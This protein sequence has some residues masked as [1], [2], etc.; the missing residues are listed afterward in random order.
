MEKR[1]I[2]KANENTLAFKQ[3]VLEQLKDYIPHDLYH[4]IESYEPTLLERNDFIKRNRHKNTVPIEER[5][6]AKSA[7]NDQ[8]TRRRKNGHTCCGT[9]SK[10]VPHGLMSL[11]KTEQ[12]ELIVQDIE[13]ILYY[14]DETNVYKTE[15]VEQK[16][17]NPRIIATWSKVGEQYKIHW[18]GGNKVI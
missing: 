15:D 16:K 17:V 18:S 4:R 13:G 12:K 6:I 2:Q 3:R 5:C 11:T 10:G 7:K 14:L 1:V 9:H 8:C